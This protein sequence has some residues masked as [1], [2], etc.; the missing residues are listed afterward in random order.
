LSNFAVALVLDSLPLST[1]PP[2]AERYAHA[3]SQG[4]VESLDLALCGH[5]GAGVVVRPSRP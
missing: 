5:D 1:H 4:L 2:K 3:F